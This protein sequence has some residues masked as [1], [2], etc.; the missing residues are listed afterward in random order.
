MVFENTATVH[1]AVVAQGAVTHP[2]AADKLIR[3]AAE[4]VE[5][6]DYVILHLDLEPRL[7]KAVAEV[8]A[9]ETSMIRLAV[10]PDTLFGSP[11][12]TTRLAKARPPMM[13]RQTRIKDTEDVNPTRRPRPISAPTRRRCST[14][15]A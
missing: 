4:I 8:Q 12:R 15:M 1:N 10:G 3:E 9:V 6:T 7:A 5:P 13:T 11:A 14:S 2:D